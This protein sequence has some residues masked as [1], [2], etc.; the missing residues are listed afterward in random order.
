MGGRGETEGRWA[1]FTIHEITRTKHEKPFRAMK[2]EKLLRAIPCV[3]VDRI[4]L[5]ILSL[6]RPGLNSLC[7]F[8]TSIPRAAAKF[9]S[10]G[11]QYFAERHILPVA[12]SPLHPVSPPFLSV[13]PSPL[14]PF[15]PSPRLLF[16]PSP[17]PSF[18][19]P[20]SLSLSLRPQHP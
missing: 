15:S 17:R 20:V 19:H 5:S 7:K 14:P 8:S 2:H 18:C 4:S 6:F 11:N 9:R 12:P 10:V 16:T 13:T 3:F 1:M